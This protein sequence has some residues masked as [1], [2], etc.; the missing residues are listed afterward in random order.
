MAECRARWCFN[1]MH[2]W[3]SHNYKTGFQHNSETLVQHVWKAK[4]LR[5]RGIIEE[6]WTIY[7]LKRTINTSFRVRSPACSFFKCKDACRMFWERYK[8]WFSP[9]SNRKKG[10]DKPKFDV[11]KQMHGCWQR[12]RG[13]RE[14]ERSRGN[15]GC[16]GHKIPTRK[17]CDGIFTPIWAGNVT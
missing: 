9:F 14:W 1:F 11:I 7:D 17:S 2:C 4:N 3:L 10:R 6:S 16:A 15:G 5:L 12:E 13:E 8:T